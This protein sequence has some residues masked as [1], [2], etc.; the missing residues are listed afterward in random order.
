MQLFSN[1]FVEILDK[2]FLVPTKRSLPL[3]EKPRSLFLNPGYTRVSRVIKHP[4]KPTDTPL[5][6][7]LHVLAGGE[8]GRSIFIP[9]PSLMERF[10]TINRD[11]RDIDI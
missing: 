10:E 8:T 9:R 2:L 11:N 5:A 6:R 4:A 7:V 3:I 1:F